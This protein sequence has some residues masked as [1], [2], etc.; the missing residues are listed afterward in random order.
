[1][2]KQQF[3]SI[4]LSFNHFFHKCSYIFIQLSNL[5]MFM[6]KCR[7]KVKEKSKPNKKFNKNPI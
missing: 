5:H 7:K 6:A 2:Q 3:Y 1:M 4:L